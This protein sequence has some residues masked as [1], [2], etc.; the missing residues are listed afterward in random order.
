MNMGGHESWDAQEVSRS[1]EVNLTSIDLSLRV[2]AKGYLLPPD[3]PPC[4]M[5]SGTDMNPGHKNLHNFRRSSWPAAQKHKPNSFHFAP[6]TCTVNRTFLF[7]ENTCAGHS[8][9]RTTNPK[10]NT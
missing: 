2:A 10:V 6:Q 7:T 5:W 1:P 4:D 9:S 3:H 8:A